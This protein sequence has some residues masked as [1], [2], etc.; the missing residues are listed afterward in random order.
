MEQQPRISIWKRK[1]TIAIAI[2]FVLNP[3]SHFL[4]NVAN[5]ANTYTISR[6]SWALLFVLLFCNKK[7]LLEK[8]EI[9]ITILLFINFLVGA[10]QGSIFLNAGLENVSATI[11]VCLAYFTVMCKKNI[12]PIQQKE[13]FILLKIIVVV[14]V[15]ATVYAMVVQNQELRFLIQ[16]V[17]KSINSWLYV[18]FFSHRNIFAL[19]CFIATIPTCYLYMKTGKKW[20]GICILWF[21]IQILLT[22]SRASLL[23]YAVFVG[24]VFYYTRKNRVVL[25]LFVVMVG[26]LLLYVFDIGSFLGENFAHITSSGEDSA[27]LRI[28]MWIESI[29]YLWDK[30]T[31]ICGFGLS[32]S[33]LFL[34]PRFNV[35]SAHNA[36]I[37]A[38][39][40]G[41]IIFLF[42]I[43]YGLIESYQKC[44]RS[45]Y[46]IEFN[47][48][49]RAAIIAYAV[50]CFFEA[51]AMLFLDAY[52][53][54]TVTILLILL[55]RCYLENDKYL[56]I[57]RN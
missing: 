14:G 53:S 43:I 46:D 57:E 32:G 9:V 11:S 47:N 2:C 42:V 31:F 34:M 20:Y 55:P 7:V 27:S 6:V 38:L 50:Y 1:T 4:Q 15:I 3:L 35:G 18:S 33:S 10:L 28:S 36:Y 17:N 29:R 41:G 19:Y 12:N 23:G 21:G 52:F 49:W 37:D 51:S 39:L 44:N 22:D 5:V 40:S 48:V 13:L 24:L 8:K 54:V 56:M 16:G 25:G 45:K 26:G 30:K